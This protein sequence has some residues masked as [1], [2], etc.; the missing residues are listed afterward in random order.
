MPQF[1][2]F[3]ATVGS[4][5]GTSAAVGGAVV[6]AGT[7]MVGSAI[8]NPIMA[9]KAGKAAGKA[10]D[11]VRDRSDREAV[12]L[13]NAQAS[14]SSQASQAVRK[15][16]ASRTQTVFTSPLGLSG[17]AATAKKRLLGE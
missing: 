11:D 17:Q 4:A 15:R 13:K 2:P 14:A 9:R 12:A 10:A 7:A 5:M 16:A 1:I 3:A 8:A 6:A